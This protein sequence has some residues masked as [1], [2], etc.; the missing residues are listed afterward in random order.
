[1]KK[2]DVAGAGNVELM[3]VLAPYGSVAAFERSAAT[4][5]G[6]GERNQS[7]YRF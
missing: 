1:L 4:A 3:A 6:A 2:V 5:Y 7:N